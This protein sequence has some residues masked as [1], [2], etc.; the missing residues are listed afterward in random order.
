MTH[1]SVSIL[2]D[3]ENTEQESDFAGKMLIKRPEITS[4]VDIDD[5]MENASPE[6]PELEFEDPGYESSTF[7]TQRWKLGSQ[8][9]HLS[10]HDDKSF[11]KLK[12]IHQSITSQENELDSKTT[13]RNIYFS[14][15][16]T[17][18]FPEP[19]IDNAVA[20]LHKT[21]C[22]KM[23]ADESVICRILGYIEALLR[24]S[25]RSIPWTTV[26]EINDQL[27]LNLDKKD[28]A[29]AKFKAVRSGAYNEF[30]KK[31]GSRETFD[32]IRFYMTRLIAD[33]DLT[34]VTTSQKKEILS[35]SRRL[36]NFLEQRRLVPKDPE[37]YGHAIVEI[38]CKNVLKS[39]NL[40]T[41]D[42]PRLKKKL[43]T[44]LHYIKKQLR[45][46]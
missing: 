25:C 12:H 8:I 22:T 19:L 1:R 43:S 45:Q 14:M 11:R 17:Q 33:I 4:F 31:R 18:W 39:R 7:K 42:D 32:V 41:L 20:E 3:S 30:Y 13:K 5:D 28:I 16:L 27:G 9:G 26:F 37:M 2:M 21:D 29:A 23:V 10:R 6:S 34:S 44:A 40:H 24:V 38:A 15:I 36:C 35:L 46:G